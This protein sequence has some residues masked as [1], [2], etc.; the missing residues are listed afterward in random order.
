MPNS[1]MKV[2]SSNINDIAYDPQSRVMSVTFRDGSTYQYLDVPIGVYERFIASDSKGGYFA[3]RIKGK[4][5]A[6]KAR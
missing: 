3:G 1:S 4:F 6:I 2:V 5:S